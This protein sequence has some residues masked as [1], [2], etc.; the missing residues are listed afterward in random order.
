MPSVLR[1]KSYGSVQITWID[2]EALWDYLHRLM[3]R[4]RSR[5]EVRAV[6][7]FGS[8]VSGEF[9]VGSDVDLL[10]V[11]DESPQ[12]FPDRIPKYLPEDAPIDVQV[13]PYTVEEI[14]RGQPL[15]LEALRTGKVLWADTDLETLLNA[16]SSPT[17]SETRS[18]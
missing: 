11:L 17:P 16:K 10:L 18:P 1:S 2:E 14:R 5:P 4:Y 8:L 12:P 13:F 15:A 7:L 9:A 3:E 6:V